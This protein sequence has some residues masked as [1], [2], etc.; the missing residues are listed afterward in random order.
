MTEFIR[1]KGWKAFHSFSEKFQFSSVLHL[2]LTLCNPMDYITPGFPVHHHL[3]SLLKLMF[4]ELVMPPNHLILSCLLLLLFNL[5]QN[6]GLFQWVSSAHQVVKSIGVSASASVLPMNILDWYPLGL[7]GMI[8]LLSKGLSSLSVP[9]NFSN[10]NLN[11]KIFSILIF[12]P[13][14]IETLY[15][16]C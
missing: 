1:T 10:S 9:L 3:P 7:T 2:C 14:G 16:Y 6:K 4:I 12:I 8:S 11:L 15:W 5:C 13:Q